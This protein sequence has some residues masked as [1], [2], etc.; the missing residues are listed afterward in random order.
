MAKKTTR[1]RA[2]IKYVLRRKD[3]DSDSGKDSEVTSSD[4]ESHVPPPLRPKRK[5]SKSPNIR[6]AKC[7]ARLKTLEQHAQNNRQRSNGQDAAAG[8][9][10]VEL[11]NPVLELR[12]EGLSKSILRLD[13]RH[14]KRDSYIRNEIKSLLKN[15]RIN[16]RLE[17]LRDDFVSQ[18]ARVENKQKAI[19]KQNDKRKEQGFKIRTLEKSLTKKLRITRHR[20]SKLNARV[21][22]VEKKLRSSKAA[23]KP[24]PSEY[25]DMQKGANHV[26]VQLGDFSGRITELERTVGT[27]AEERRN[28]APLSHKSSSVLLPSSPAE[29]FHRQIRYLL[30]NTAG[31][32]QPSFK[33]R[34][35]WEV[36]QHRRRNGVLKLVSWVPLVRLLMG[37]TR[38]IKPLAGAVIAKHTTLDVHQIHTR[39]G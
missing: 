7:R 38:T 18:R 19:D 11:P 33:A 34:R 4:E 25:Q 3:E 2:K 10:M 35:H 16:D 22:K 5:R 27:Q 36:Q 6:P 39:L 28:R 24:E 23:V 31:S 30:C 37:T 8:Q 9:G 12:L 14:T 1:P 29:Q 26:N 15:R 13:D 20:N 21:V 17:A 32:L